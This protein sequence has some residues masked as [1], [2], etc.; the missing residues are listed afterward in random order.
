MKNS[1][2]DN[3]WNK[4]VQVT[5]RL[6][7]KGFTTKDIVEADR[8]VPM[9]GLS[10]PAPER[11]QKDQES[12]MEK[13]K[14]R[15]IIQ[16]RK[17]ARQAE[18]AR[19]GWSSRN[20]NGA[21]KNDAKKPRMS[22]IP[23]LSLLEI[24]KVMTYGAEKYAAWNWSEGTDYSVLVDA[25]QRHIT[26]FNCGEDKDPESGLSHLGHAMCCLMMLYDVTQMYPERDD[27]WE[28][29]LEEKG[30]K[31]FE[32]NNK[33]YEPTDYLR[34]VLSALEEAKEEE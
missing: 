18:I 25:A 9:P 31:A 27:R 26:A 19:K 8:L 15:K 10:R 7:E 2:D 3:L 23:Q 4:T 13:E 28:G 22:L 1:L 33:P 17:A 34:N 32:R 20:K 6:S 16:E 5:N 29:F 11:V 12:K 21:V 24:A 30:K 14:M